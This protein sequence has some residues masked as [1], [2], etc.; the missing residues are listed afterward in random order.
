MGA[1]P[2]KIEGGQKCKKC[3]RTMQRKTHPGHWRPKKDQ[4]YFFAYWDICKCGMI[5]LY[6]DAKVILHGGTR[7][8]IEAEFREIMKG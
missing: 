1:K 6:E 8:Q 4:P 7:S 3:R 5:Q 2:V